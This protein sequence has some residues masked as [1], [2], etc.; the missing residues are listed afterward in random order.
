MGNVTVHIN[1]ETGASI[2]E[3]EASMAKT[4]ASEKVG[5]LTSIAL[6][7][8]LLAKFREGLGDPSHDVK[9][10]APSYKRQNTKNGHADLKGNN[11]NKV[12]AAVGGLVTLDA[13]KDDDNPPIVALVGSVPDF[14]VNNLRGGVSLESYNSNAERKNY[15]KGLGA[16]YTDTTIVILTNVNS[17]MHGKERANWLALFVKINVAPGALG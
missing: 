8:D 5:L 15:L 9:P 3:R 13:I 12:T 11:N 7:N 4:F 17:T 1:S 6:S 2:G 16:A 10:D 14:N